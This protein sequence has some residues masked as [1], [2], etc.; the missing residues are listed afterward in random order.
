[1][2]P[3]TRSAVRLALLG[4]A[5]ILLIAGPAGAQ[6]QP[7]EL[8]VKPSVTGPLTRGGRV[9]FRVTSTHPAGF[10]AVQTVTIEADLRGA[11]LEEIAYDADGG[12][13]AVG[14]AKAVIGT[15]DQVTGRFFRVSALDV[16]ATTGGDELTVTIGADVLEALPQGTR[17]R[18][19]AEDN[20][21]EEAVRSV[22]AS[23]PEEEGG[24][25]LVTVILAIV[26]ALVAGGFLGSRL[27]GS[28]RSAP[29]IYGTVSR[30]IQ[31]ER[32]ARSRGASS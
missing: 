19:T 8:T 4:L 3:P 12:A 16:S 29:S 27:T 20:L 10:A 31:D 30:R 15:G 22:Q 2:D 21:G 5:T 13:I 32:N 9:T 28:R 24:L 26:A 23:V 25:S 17:F 1:M 11:T 6:E 18:F 14:E 7:K